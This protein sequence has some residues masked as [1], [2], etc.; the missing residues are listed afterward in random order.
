MCQVE[1]EAQ[2]TS[3]VQFNPAVWDLSI[4]NLNLPSKPSEPSQKQFKWPSQ[5][6]SQNNEK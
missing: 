4:K 3:D 1:I 5:H 2:L 6:G